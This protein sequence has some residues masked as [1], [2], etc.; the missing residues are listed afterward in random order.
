M[1]ENRDIGIKYTK[2]YNEKNNSFISGACIT[3]DKDI[4]ICENGSILKKLIY[5][6]MNDKYNVELIEVTLAEN[7]K[8]IAEYEGIIYLLDNKKKCIITYEG[9]NRESIFLLLPRHEQF[10][11]AVQGK[12][13]F[14]KTIILRK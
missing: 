8:A 4:I 7:I 2:L 10:I 6:P 11:P 5:K 9:I 3:Q 14:M 12:F 13:I 1:I